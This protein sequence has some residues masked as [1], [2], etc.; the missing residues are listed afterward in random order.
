M[1][2]YQH[3]LWDG[4][5]HTYDKRTGELIRNDD[6]SSLRIK[7]GC[8]VTLYKDRWT[9]GDNKEVCS[10]VSKDELGDG[11][12]DKVSS[13][14]LYRSMY[15]FRDWSV[16]MMHWGQFFQKISGKISLHC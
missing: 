2:F 1:E 15:F 9:E 8:C 6:M 4:I 5:K 16:S 11:W 7:P 12:N 10:S 13:F 3:G 14:T